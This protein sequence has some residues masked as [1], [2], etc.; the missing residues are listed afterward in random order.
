MCVI[1]FRIKK[2]NS[3]ETKLFEVF[4][5]IKRKILKK[6][7]EHNSVVEANTSSKAVKIFRG[8]N[9]PIVPKKECHRHHMFSR[10]PEV[11]HPILHLCLGSRT[12]ISDFPLRHF[13]SLLLV[14]RV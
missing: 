7:T 6:L 1:I 5:S 4:S 11:T 2:I 10:R 12:L 9:E 8:E 14:V 13:F 3:V